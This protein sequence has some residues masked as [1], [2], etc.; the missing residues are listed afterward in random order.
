MNLLDVVV[1]TSR[2]LCT[3]EIKAVFRH[4][5]SGEY[6]TVRGVVPCRLREEGLAQLE[7]K[8]NKHYYDFC[9]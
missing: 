3:R 5:P 9:G 8:V 6:V 2:D 4:I 1:L 7:R